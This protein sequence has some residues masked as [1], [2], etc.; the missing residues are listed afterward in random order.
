MQKVEYSYLQKQ[1][2]LVEHP[3]ADAMRVKYIELAK[4]FR[5]ERTFDA[6]REL[7][8]AGDFTLGAQVVEFERRF[9]EM[10]GTPYAIGVNSGTDAL[11][12]PL[13]ALG[14]GPGDEVITQVNTF[15]ATAGAIVQA[16]ATPVFADVLDDMTI[17]PTDVARKITP[18]TKAVMPVHWTGNVGNVTAVLDVAKSSG[19]YVIEDS[20]QA[21]GARLAEQSSGSFGIAAGFSLHPLKNLNV[22]GDGGV[23]TTTSEDLA[24]RIRLLR[25]HGLKNRD[26]VQMW[27]Y[28]S[29]LDTL[30]AIVALVLM[31]DLDDITN[32]RIANA[33]Y[34]DDALAD[35]QPEVQ[36][37]P[38][39]PM[40]RHVYHL[41]Q[42]YVERRDDLL[43]HL[44]GR[45]IEAK[46]HYPIPLHLQEAAAGLGYK[47]GDFPEAERQAA[48][49]ITLPVHQHL[50]QEQLEY[51]VDAIRAFYRR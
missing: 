35:L 5:A 2:A 25:N 21:A 18:K 11:F 44:V 37:P 50:Q 16:G 4:G 47:R 19:L 48:R 26:E 39:T 13:K 9:A 51:T 3:E 34:F 6:I 20:A 43:A 49:I 28:N 14:I 31:D 30:Q 15:V 45:G 8:K 40:V 32:R 46:V 10:C 38:R 36:I 7:L 22:W 1:F 17:D 29:R 24:A 12:L 33:S 27:G 41:Y 42:L 23:V